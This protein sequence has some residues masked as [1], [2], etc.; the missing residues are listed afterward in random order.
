MKLSGCHLGFIGFGHM[1]QGLFEAFSK[2]KMI[3]NSQ[4]FFHRKDPHKAKETEKKFHITSTG[5]RNLVRSS[6]IILLAVRPNQ[7]EVVL[8]DLASLGVQEKMIISILAGVEI[9]FFQKFLGTSTQ[10]L[11]TMPNLASIVGEGVT[12]CSYSS[13]A[14]SE[15]KNLSHLLFSAAGKVIELEEKFMDLAVGMSGSSPG[16]IFKLIEAHAKV[17]VQGGIPYE[18]ALMMAAQT[19]YG[20]AKLIL[21]GNSPQ[22]L[23]EG[24][25]VP[26]GTTEAGFQS[27]RKNEVEKHFQGAILASIEKSKEIS[28]KI[29]EAR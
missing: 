20:A 14:S 26:G 7:A 2:C 29:R 6:E 23:I 1:A 22:K 15:F 9:S 16:F 8:R 19:F 11:R 3:P 24:I 10:I 21:E 28:E 12:V 4:I 25:A 5:L 17:G 13:N 27:M 18:K